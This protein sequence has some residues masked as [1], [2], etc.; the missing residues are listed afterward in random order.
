MPEESLDVARAVRIPLGPTG[1]GAGGRR[2]ADER[3]FLRLPALYRVLSST[4][5]RLP[6]RS[7]L[8]RAMVARR[9]RQAYAAANRRDFD[10]VLMGWQRDSEYRP[11]AD[12][13][14]PDL[15]T[16]FHGH[17]GYLELWRHWLDAF[18]DIRWDPEEILDLGDRLLVTTRQSGRGSGSGVAVS[19]PVFQLF[20]L[21]SGLVTRQED[22]LDRSKAL[23]AATCGRSPAA[24]TDTRSG[25]GTA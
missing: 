22:F 8:R 11:A 9:M 14:P 7:R 15:K 13:M 1:D 18:D 21:R 2:A 20:T 5:M 23:D 24:S 4:L 17:D 12:L 3:L 16:V 10:V 25:A 19:E 6:P